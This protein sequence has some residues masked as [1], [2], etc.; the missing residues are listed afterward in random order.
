ML[1]KK[2]SQNITIK[3]LSSKKKVINAL[4]TLEFPVKRTAAEGQRKSLKH[5]GNISKQNE[6]VNWNQSVTVFE[7]FQ[8][9]VIKASAIVGS[10]LWYVSCLSDYQIDAFENSW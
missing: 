2:N 1:E 8:E 9:K 4:A 5:Q 7:N 6:R 3:V 10:V